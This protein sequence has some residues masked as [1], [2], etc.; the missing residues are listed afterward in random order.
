MLAA[1]EAVEC[2]GVL[3]LLDMMEEAH[4]PGLQLLN[5]GLEVIGGYP[6]R[7]RSGGAALEQSVTSARQAPH[8]D[9]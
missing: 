2:H 6:R 9:T 1:T 5:D 8:V 3:W 4:T 7:R